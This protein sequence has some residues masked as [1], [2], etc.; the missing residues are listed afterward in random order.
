MERKQEGLFMNRYGTCIR[1][2]CEGTLYDLKDA[3]QT[4]KG[5]PIR[6]L[7]CE[8]CETVYRLSV[9]EWG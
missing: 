3:A 4:L 2:D 1:D 6:A 8:D 7:Q 5:M 9:L